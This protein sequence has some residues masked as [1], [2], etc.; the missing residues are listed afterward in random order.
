[1]EKLDIRKEDMSHGDVG[2]SKEKNGE[3]IH[4][5]LFSVLL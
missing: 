3:I 4:A 2:V 1:M 5:R